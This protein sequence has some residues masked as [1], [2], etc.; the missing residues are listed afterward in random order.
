MEHMVSSCKSLNLMIFLRCLVIAGRL[1]PN[2]SATAAGLTRLFHPINLRLIAHVRLWPYK[3]GSA[4]QFTFLYFKYLF[5]YN[6][7]YNQIAGFRKILAEA[8]RL[9]NKIFISNTIYYRFGWITLEV[10]YCAS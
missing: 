8:K 3:F 7:R 10:M 5:G 9:Y 2:K 6:H 4:S 1:V